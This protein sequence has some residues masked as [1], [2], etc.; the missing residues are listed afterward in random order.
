MP[1]SQA[2]ASSAT[3]RRRTAGCA[4][5][6]G[7]ALSGSALPVMTLGILIADF[8]S[9]SAMPSKS[10]RRSI[11]RQTSSGL[12]PADAHRTVRL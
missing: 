3:I 2:A 10:S 6:L 5:A 1:L 9:F 12:T 4:A 8:G 7:S 11:S